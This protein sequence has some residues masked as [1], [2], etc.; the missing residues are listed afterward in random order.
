MQY[1]AYQLLTCLVA[2]ETLQM[3]LGIVNRHDTDNCYFSSRSPMHILCLFI[4]LSVLF[5]LLVILRASFIFLWD[6]LVRVEYKRYRHQTSREAVSATA[7]CGLR[8]TLT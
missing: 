1:I 6:M 7:T 2:N 4:S 3:N 5:T 8:R